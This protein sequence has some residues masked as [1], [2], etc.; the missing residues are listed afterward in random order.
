MFPPSAIEKHYGISVFM[1]SKPAPAGIPVFGKK[2][3]A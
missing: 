3:P 2:E 1:N